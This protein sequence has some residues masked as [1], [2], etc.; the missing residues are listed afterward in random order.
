MSNNKTTG[1]IKGENPDGDLQT[2]K[3]NKNGE[4]EVT[5]FSSKDVLKSILLA[6]QVIIQQNNEVHD[7]KMDEK[8]INNK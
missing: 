5:N 4:L 2:I 3:T 1:E 8:D 7:L 6:L